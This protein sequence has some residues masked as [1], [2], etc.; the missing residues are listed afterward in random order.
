MQQSD[1]LNGGFPKLRM[2]SW[3]LEKVMKRRMVILDSSLIRRK[4]HIQ[5]TKRIK[6]KALAAKVETD[7]LELGLNNQIVLLNSKLSKAQARVKTFK[8]EV[9][10]KAEAETLVRTLK[11]EVATL[12]EDAQACVET[13]EKEMKLKA[14]AETLVGTLQG[15]VATLKGESQVRVETFKKLIAEAETLVGTLQGEVATLKGES[16]V[17]VETFEKETKLKAEAETLVGTYYAS[18]K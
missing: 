13:S 11:G 18:R 10:L 14:E 2:I 8:G 15:E 4:Q 9:K 6:K 17:R 12:E 3:K 7:Q 1:I 5:T 16:Q